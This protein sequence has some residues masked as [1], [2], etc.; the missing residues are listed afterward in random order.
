MLTEALNPMLCLI[1]LFVVLEKKIYI[2]A[3]H[4][5]LITH[6]DKKNYLD[7]F[8]ITY[9]KVEAATA[10]NTGLTMIAK[11]QLWGF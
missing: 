10:L 4:S 8:L 2:G 5:Y 9:F 7:K 3:F 1:F 6:M 11:F